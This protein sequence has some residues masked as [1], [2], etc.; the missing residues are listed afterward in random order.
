MFN[1]GGLSVRKV[2]N[3]LADAGGYG[4]GS[5]DWIGKGSY[6][7]GKVTLGAI[8]GL[9]YGLLVRAWRSGTGRRLGSGY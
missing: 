5:G 2:E 4:A 8:S 9:P 6:E 1:G 3:R 7:E